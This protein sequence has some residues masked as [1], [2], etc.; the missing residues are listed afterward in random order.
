MKF[1]FKSDFHLEFHV[2]RTDIRLL[3]IEEAVRQYARKM[4]KDTVG[5]ERLLVLLGGDYANTN[6]YSRYFIDEICKL[7][8]H[9]FVVFGNHDLYLNSPYEEA[10]YDGDSY[11]R[12]EELKKYLASHKNLSILENFSEVVGK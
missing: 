11:G 3:G 2:K 1:L 9:V 10:V 8:D 5:E 6:D 4:Y 12:I 7:A